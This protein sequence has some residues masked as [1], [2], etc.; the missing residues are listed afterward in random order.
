MKKILC[1]L[2]LNIFL[3]S[4]ST[5]DESKVSNK[6]GKTEI[7][8]WTPFTG[9]DGQDMQKIIDQY[10]KENTDEI[11]VRFEAIQ[12]SDMYPKFQTVMSSKKGGP[13]IIAVHSDRVVQYQ[14]LGLINPLDDYLPV[15]D[16][17]KEKII[18]AI[19]EATEIDGKRYSVPLDVHPIFLFYN[20]DLLAKAGYKEEDLKELSYEKFIEMME[21]IMSLNSEY[22]GMTTD[23]NAEFMLEKIFYTALVQNG[24]VIVTKEDPYTPKY[25]SPEGIKAAEQIIALKKYSTPEGTQGIN[26]FQNGEALFHLSGPWDINALKYVEGKLEWG[27]AMVPKFGPNK[28]VWTGS[29]NI[30][31]PVTVKKEKMEA[32]SK[33]LAYLSKNSIAWAK[34]GQVPANLEVLNSEEFSKLK[35]AVI[36]DNLDYISFPPEV[37]TQSEVMEKVSFALVDLFNGKTKDV[38]GS[39]NAAAKEGAELASTYKK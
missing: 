21:K 18:P 28:G 23:I 30:V 29:H 2:L 9:S 24:G 13:D 16:I 27:M 14:Y 22:Y 15:I 10:N 7:I 8:F 20:K 5:K 31:V 12:A 26:F 32:I 11:V 4:C 37:P 17:S 25:N 35:W 38:K 34:A 6:N 39:L 1:I 19:W 33:F 36:K 3:I